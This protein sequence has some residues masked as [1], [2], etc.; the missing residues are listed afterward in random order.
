MAITAIPQVITALAEGRMIRGADGE[1]VDSAT[2]IALWRI[3]AG[4]TARLAGFLATAGFVISWIMA[5]VDCFQPSPLGSTSWQLAFALKLV[6]GVSRFEVYTLGFL[7]YTSQ[8]A[9]V[10]YLC[11]YLVMIFTFA[12][13]IQDYTQFGKSPALYPDI[14]ESDTR[15]GFERLEPFINGVLLASVAYFCQFFMTRLYYIYVDD[16]NA[17]SI[18]DIIKEAMGRDFG[19]DINQLVTASGP[20]FFDYGSGLH[21]QSTIMGFAMLIVAISAITVPTILVQSAAERSRIRLIEAIGRDRDVAM[22]WYGLDAA[23]AHERLQK[24]TIWPIR[25]PRPVELLLL[26]VLATACFFFYKL[27]LFVLALI[28]LQALRY[29]TGSLKRQSGGDG[30]A[31]GSAQSTGP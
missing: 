30:G 4:T 23:K 16:P 2:L 29:F 11:Y 14:S 8:G 9:A 28:V 17:S 6:P 31:A 24:M 21:F 22:R 7:A 1:L 12:T 10:A 26:V 19:R 20:S 13:W 3:R 15:C 25:Y 18:F 5:W 27:L